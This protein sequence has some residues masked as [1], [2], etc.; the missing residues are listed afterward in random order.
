MTSLNSFAAGEISNTQIPQ[1]HGAGDDKTGYETKYYT[2]K[3]KA[4]TTRVGKKTDLL[5]LIKQPP[6]G[7]PNVPIPANNPISVEKIALGRKLFYDRR[8]SLNSTFSCAMCHVPEQGFTHNELAT[9]V[10]LEG[11]SGRRNSPTLF[12]IAYAEKLFHDGREDTLEQQVWGPLLAHNEMGNPSP[13]VVLRKIRTLND[14][15]GLFENVFNKPVNM[16]TLGMALATYQR[17]LNSANSPFDQWYFGHNDA[18]VTPSVKRGFKLFRG[19]A[20]CIACHTVNNDSA[21]FTDHKLHNTG[22]GFSV[23]TYQRPKKQRLLVAPGQYIEID[24]DLFDSV[25]EKK[26]NDVGLYEITEDPADRW[27]YKTPTLRNISLTAPYMHDGAFKT[28]EEVVNFYNHGGTPNE[29]LDPLIK[30]LGLT[31]NEIQDILAFLNSLT[32][33]NVDELIADGFAAPV[34]DTQ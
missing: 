25:S 8:L 26:P 13:G 19:K 5:S 32:G 29:E 2:T 15:N 11:R 33:S 4:L 24:S 6:L 12:N 20:N 10:G 18:A 27:K 16:E 1:L 30:P 22:H 21:V 34:G 7:L 31:P 23:S 14:Y 28:L 3:S 9:A 17:S